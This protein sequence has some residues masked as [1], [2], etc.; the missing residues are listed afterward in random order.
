MNNS[1]CD[2]PKTDA[3]SSLDRER[4]EWEKQRQQEMQAIMEMKRALTDSWLALETEQRT[5][6]SRQVAGTQSRTVEEFGGTANAGSSNPQSIEA[7]DVGV[8][9]YPTPS[10]SISMKEN[11]ECVLDAT[12]IRRRKPI[13]LFQL[14]REETWRRQS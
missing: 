12:T 7:E 4:A 6:R 13:E 8:L 14:L 1:Q 5:L 3:H 10:N 11:E 9:N 2:S